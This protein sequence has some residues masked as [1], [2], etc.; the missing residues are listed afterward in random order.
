MILKTCY[1]HFYFL[2][3]K[4][5][6]EKHVQMNNK[7]YNSNIENNKICL[8]CLLHTILHLF[9]NDRVTLKTGVHFKI[10]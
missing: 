4:I 6:L 5:I 2:F 1:K 9:L 10:Y 7:Q 8:L 3:I